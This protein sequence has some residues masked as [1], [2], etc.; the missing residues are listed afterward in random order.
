MRSTPFRPF[1]R[2]LSD[3]AP[4]LAL[5]LLAAGLLLFA[6]RSARHRDGA[7]DTGPIPVALVQYSSGALY[8]ETSQGF[9]DGLAARG[10]VHGKRITLQRFN[11]EGDLPTVNLIAS[12]VTD[13]SFR[14]IAGA[15]TLC[16]QALAN[17]NRQ[18]RTPQV[19]WA[20]SAPI[21]AGVGIKALDDADAKPPYLAGIGTSQPVEAIFR[22]AVKIRPELKKVGV[23][24]NPAEANSEV[25]TI[26]ARAICKELGLELLEAPIEGTRDI[27]EAAESVIQRGA[28][29]FWTGGDATV[30]SAIDNLIS[31]ARN[32]KIPVF[33]NVGGHI[34]S[35]AL[36]DLG[37]NYYQV[38]F[39][40]GEIGGDILNGKPAAEI[41]VTDFM[42]E[43]IG[44]NQKA[45][46]GLRANWTPSPAILEQAGSLIGPDGEIVRQPS[47]E[48]AR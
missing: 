15:S 38:G 34:R 47:R 14:L 6:D 44:F 26:R 42:P 19:F 11:G 13:G 32:H 21:A 17:A 36:F 16:L 3:L 29:A 8:D 9:I 40:A 45:A 20:V 46:L 31:T 7:L 12:R 10:Y 18:G 37:A 22:L 23:V 24:W 39:R 43:V 33:S 30:I 48:A 28:E 2:F 41:A 5:V 25:C 35:G 27:K 4:G 1:F